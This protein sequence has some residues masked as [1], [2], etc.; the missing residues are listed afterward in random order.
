MTAAAPA[1]L[2]AGDILLILRLPKNL[3]N[4]HLPPI[5]PSHNVWVNLTIAEVIME[6]VVV[7]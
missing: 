3:H 6:V 1:A 2:A 4:L 5:L 7:V